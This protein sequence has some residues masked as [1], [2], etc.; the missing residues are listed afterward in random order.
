MQD[1]I[2]TPLQVNYSNYCPVVYQ[3]TVSPDKCI[4][5]FSHETRE[6]L[7]IHNTEMENLFLTILTY[8][9]LLSYKEEQV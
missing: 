5:R 1:I 4:S 9:V 6:N 7:H 8:E 3:N 2:Y